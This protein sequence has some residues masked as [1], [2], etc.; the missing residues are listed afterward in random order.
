[1]VVYLYKKGRQTMKNII[2]TIAMF[3]LTINVYAQ[4]EL[5]HKILNEINKYRVENGLDTIVWNDKAYPIAKNQ[6]LYMKLSGVLTHNQTINVPNF[7]EQPNFEKRVSKTGLE[8]GGENLAYLV[9]TFENISK[10]YDEMAKLTVQMWKQSPSHNELLLTNY[11]NVG[12]VSVMYN[13]FVIQNGVK[14]DKKFF[15]VSLEV[16][17]K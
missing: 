16:F 9:D 5:E 15:L 11:Y 14:Y 1:M 2:T 13:N 3:I 4:V 12:A 17:W 7:V 10:K 8:F 6:S